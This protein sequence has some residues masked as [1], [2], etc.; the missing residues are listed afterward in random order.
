MSFFQHFL[1]AVPLDGSG[2]SVVSRKNW[3]RTMASIGMFPWAKGHLAC[4]RVA[5]DTTR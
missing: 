4:R 2:S 3:T 5:T 1:G